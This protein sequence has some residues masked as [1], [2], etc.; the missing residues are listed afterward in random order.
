M[1]GGSI[2][3]FGVVDMFAF[4]VDEKLGLRLLDMEG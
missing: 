4:A 3:R 2:C 1:V